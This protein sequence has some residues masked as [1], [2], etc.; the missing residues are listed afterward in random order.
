MNKTRLTICLFL[1]ITSVWTQAQ[2]NLQPIGIDFFAK[3]RSISNV[4]TIGDE[5]FFTLRQANIKDDN[6]T[7][8][9]FQLVEGKAVR[10]TNTGHFGGYE[11][12][13]EAIVT[14]KQKDESTIFLK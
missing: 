11:I 5:I 12:I 2:T 10:L 3:I 1:A 6:Y 13:G 9:L 7:T 8:D 14:Q 4:K